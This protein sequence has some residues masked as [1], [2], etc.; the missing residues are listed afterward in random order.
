MSAFLGGLTLTAIVSLVFVRGYPAA[1]YRIAAT[2]S[3][4]L[5]ACKVLRA[6]AAVAADTPARRILRRGYAM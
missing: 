2:G 4:A 3:A 1:D 5:R 6:K